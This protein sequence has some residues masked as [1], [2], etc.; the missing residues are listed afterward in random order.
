[1]RIRVAD[2]PK[3]SQ[4]KHLPDAL[5]WLLGEWC[6]NGHRKYYLTNHPVGTALHTL[7]AT[8][9][10]PGVCEQA[11]QQLTEELGLDHSEGRSWL[12]LHHHTLFTVLAFTLLPPHRLRTLGGNR[13]P[14]AGP[15]LPPRLPA[16][17]RALLA[18]LKP[19]VRLRCPPSARTSRIT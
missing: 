14:V 12:G 2:G 15:P 6:A 10:A 13:T 19:P 16:V 7:A 9:K 17:R 1:M 8:I 4:G 5:A 18:A 3:A 11:H